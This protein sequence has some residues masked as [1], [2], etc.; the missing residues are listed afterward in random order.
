[1]KRF[2][3]GGPGALL[4]PFFICFVLFWAMPL[5][6]GVRIS[7]HSNEIA[8]PTHFVGMDNYRNVLGDS[9]YSTAL[10]NTTVYAL[11]SIGVILPFSLWLAFVL[12]TA[13]RR[14]RP[15]LSFL[16]LLPAITPPIVLGTLFLLVFHGR[17]GILNQ[18]FVLPF[19][20]KAINWLKDPDWILTGLILQSIWRWT[21]FVTF[22]L[23]C[24]L[25]GIP[26][27]YA[28]SSSL[29]GARPW[30]T[31]WRIQVPL[32]GPMILFV[33]AYL[34]IDAF[35]MFSGAYTILGNSGGTGDAGLM[36]VTYTYQTAFEPFNAFGRATASSLTLLPLIGLVFG[37]GYMLFKRFTKPMQEARS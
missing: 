28:E 7:L 6:D 13:F 32:L 31:F 25:E 16:L 23:L 22:F 5:I 17:E 29:D 15:V 3:S 8:G 37:M 11:A 19:G 10:K 33:T 1:M 12:K 14:L 26:K 18:L 9:R 36:L 21:G 24:G 35:A 27:S 30:Q 34:L 2:W 20:F 4:L